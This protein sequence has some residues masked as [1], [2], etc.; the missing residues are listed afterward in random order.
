MTRFMPWPVVLNSRLGNALCD[1]QIQGEQ[2][3][4][5]ENLVHDDFVEHEVLDDADEALELLADVHEEENA[6]VFERMVHAV[7]NDAH[8][9]F[10]DVLVGEVDDADFADFVQ[11]NEHEDLGQRLP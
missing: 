8:D 9:A 5:A 4:D 7:E 3:A 10:D 1:L 11:R 6:V 2:T